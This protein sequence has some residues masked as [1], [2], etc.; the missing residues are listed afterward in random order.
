MRK[1]KP[2]LSDDVLHDVWSMGDNAPETGSLTDF[3]KVVAAGIARC[4][5]E[6]GRSRAEIAKLISSVLN[7]KISVHMLN[8]YSSE[9]RRDHP[10]S[11]YRFLALISLTRRFDI[12][13]ATLRRI[14]V[15]ALDRS[16]VG[17]LKLGKAYANL[18]DANEKLDSAT[19]DFLLP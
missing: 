10:C 14:G 1:R 16:D 12:L 13:D 11:A 15:K 2:A 17:I 3:D 19:T 9:S 18:L 4:L 7:E 6:D 8:A 5:I